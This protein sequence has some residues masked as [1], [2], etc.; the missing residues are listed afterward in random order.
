MRKVGFIS[1]FSFIFMVPMAFAAD[2]P[3]KALV[4]GLKVC[5]SLE[6]CAPAQALIRRGQSIWPA[7]GEGLNAPDEMTR[8]WTLGVLSE[9]PVAAAR[10]AIS[11]C[12][13]DPEIRVRAAAAYALGAQGSRAVT[14]ALIL[15]LKDKDLNVRFAAAV[16]LARV[17]DPSS[18]DALIV[19]CGDEDE[20]VRA[21]AALALGDIGD[22]RATA[23]VMK[24]LE[25]DHVP[26]VRGF[27]GMALSKLKDPSTLTPLMNHVEVESDP[28]ALAATL[29]ALGALGDRRALPTV[30]RFI[31]HPN[32][33][34]REYAQ[35]AADQLSA[36]GSKP[37]ESPPSPPA[38]R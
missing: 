33:E 38:K 8:F 17:K 34:V 36:D 18:V 3:V 12:V 13:G 27:A 25:R 7:V 28:K 20:D 37:K 1:W 19:A 5:E 16:A 26:R 4:D 14:P 21:Y 31:K 9:V 32:V 35:E 2:P 6:T 10:S 15:A 11:R 29:Y 30:Q 22:R 23:A 24:R